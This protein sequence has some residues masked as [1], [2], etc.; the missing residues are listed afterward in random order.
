MMLIGKRGTVISRI[1][2]E[3]GQDLMNAF[4]CDVRLKLKVEVKS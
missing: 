4:L 2:Q 3:A 1:A